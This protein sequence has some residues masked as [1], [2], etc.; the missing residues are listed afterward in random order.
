MPMK[1]QTIKKQ[2]S[3]PRAAAAKPSPGPITI[4]T[5][6]RL[7]VVV[8]SEPDCFLDMVGAGR[9]VGKYKP[10]DLVFLQGDPADNVFYIQKGEVR[11]TVTSKQAKEGVIAILKAGQFF[12][13]G[14]LVGQPVNLGTAKAAVDSA[15]VKIGKQSMRKAMHDNPA[16]SEKFMAHLLSRNAMVEAELVDHLFNSS[17]KRL[18]RVLLL[19]AQT[20]KEATMEPVPN[21]NQAILAA[22]VGTTRSRISFFMN[23]FRELGYIEYNGVLKV[24]TALMNV[25]IHD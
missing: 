13:E 20:G 11:I 25:V 19:L 7:N 9:V 1:K 6:P 5:D 16:F 17:E 21:I 22:R 10:G 15:I 4:R 23:R 3:K 24:N 14:C 8:S 2:A 12:G 18:A